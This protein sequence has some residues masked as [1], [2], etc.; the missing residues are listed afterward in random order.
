[1]IKEILLRDKL[2]I[3]QSLEE[4]KKEIADLLRNYAQ[5]NHR[6]QSRTGNLRNSTETS[7]KDI[8]SLYINKAKAEYG[9]YIHDGFKSWKADPFIDKAIEDNLTKIEQIID[10]NIDKYLR[11]GT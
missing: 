11:Y 2:L 3:D 1:M 7:I 5:N 6:Y 4:S 9:S 8:V 10:K